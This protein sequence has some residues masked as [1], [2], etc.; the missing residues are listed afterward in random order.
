MNLGVDANFL[1][2]E[3]AVCSWGTEEVDL[4]KDSDFVDGVVLR[5]RWGVG[6]YCACQRPDALVVYRE[7]Q[8]M[9]AAAAPC[10]P[11]KIVYIFLCKR[12]GSLEN[13]LSKVM[14]AVACFRGLFWGS[15]LPFCFF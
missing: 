9:V 2:E 7:I 14:S 6:V 1:A 5:K 8:W 15:K 3:E 11:V 12:E 10:P 13:R 4:G